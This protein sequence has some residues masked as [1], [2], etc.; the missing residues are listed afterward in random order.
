[1]FSLRILH[2]T[3]SGFKANGKNT[4]TA[5]VHLQK[6]KLIGGMLSLRPRAM[7]K[8]PDHI[9]VAPIEKK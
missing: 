6:A 4:I 5:T 8:L 2:S 1:M 9:A 7:I 3:I